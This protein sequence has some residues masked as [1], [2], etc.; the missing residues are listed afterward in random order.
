MMRR[1]SKTVASTT[2]NAVTATAVIWCNDV[3]NAQN[4]SK[5]T[6]PVK[7]KLQIILFVWQVNHFI[8]LQQHGGIF[9]CVY[10]YFL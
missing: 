3:E 7:I 8:L 9:L 1:F 5:Q 6:S 4:K 10:N 2:V